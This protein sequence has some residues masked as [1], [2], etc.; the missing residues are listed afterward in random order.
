[1]DILTFNNGIETLRRAVLERV[2]FVK[3]DG[4]HVS[5]FRPLSHEYFFTS[6]LPFTTGIT[7]HLP[8][9]VPITR[10]DFS[11]TFRG[12][13]RLVYEQ[14]VASLIGRSVE[15]KDADVKVFV[16]Y[17]KTNFTLKSNPVPRVISPRS[18]R[19]NVEIGR[20]IRP[21]EERLFEAI[22]DLYGMRTIVKGMN[23][24]DSG[25]LLHRKW[26]AFNNP[27]AVGLD[28]ERFDQH[29]S[30]PALEYEHMLYTRCFWR[31]KDKSRL[32]W[33]LSWQLSNKC[34]GNTPDGWLKYQVDGCRMSGDMNTSLGNCVLMC[35]MVYSY[36]HS[37]GVRVH[38]ANNGDDC[39]VFMDNRDLN[40]FMVGLRPWFILMGFS[41]MCEEPVR[42]F[43]RL[44]FCQTQPVWVG[45]D[46]G[47]YLMVRDPRVA[48]C[49][50]TISV[51]PLDTPQEL[52]GWLSA[53]GQGGMALTGQLPVWQH[54]YHMYIRS[55][56]GKKSHVDTGWGWGV[57]KLGEGMTRKFGPIDPKTRFSFW[58]AF[59]IT[60]DQQVCI[61]DVFDG[62]GIALYD[63]KAV[64]LDI[65]LPL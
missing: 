37:I 59:G 58:L 21:I 39:V 24:I 49:K 45:P 1:M 9:T 40:R 4:R 53:V 25:R 46:V 51:K 44:Q 52:S 3:R 47:D 48:I 2:F 33:L 56:T 42:D 63:N 34:S 31:R 54:F 6:L 60:P 22:G 23:A 27:V 43:E 29:V 30:V 8:S 12:R 11:A 50:D 20:Y 35:A 14:A 7:R 26:C 65:M 62:R 10:A 36:A 61:E 64:P 13:K 38:L 5:P 55:A 15:R 17:E 18:P 19:Y 32:S 41:L 57:R 16:K 28:A